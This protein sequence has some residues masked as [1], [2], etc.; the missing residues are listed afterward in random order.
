MG[1]ESKSKMLAEM[2]RFRGVKAR[3]TSDGKN[4]IIVKSKVGGTIARDLR[5]RPRFNDANIKIIEQ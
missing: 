5:K 4:N 2:I 1:K 3:R